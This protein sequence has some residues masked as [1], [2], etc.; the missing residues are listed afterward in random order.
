MSFRFIHNA[1]LHFDAPLTT[2]ALR[3]PAQA[4]S[5]ASLTAF[6]RI[7]DLCIEEAVAFLLITDDLS[8]GS[9]SAATTPR[10]LKQELLRL[11][12]A[13]TR[14]F[15]IRG[16]HDALAHL[17]AE[18]A[19]LLLE[20]RERANALLASRF[21][22]LAFDVGL[23]RY[24]DRHRSAMLARASDAFSQLSRGAYSGLAAQP[25][26]AQEVLVVLP[27]HGG[28]EL[29]ADLSKGTRFQLYLALRI[30]GYHEPAQSRPTLPVIADDI[31]ETFDND[32]LPAAFVLL[33]EMSRVGQ[34]I[35]L[36]RHRHLCK[37][38]LTACPGANIIE[39]S[40][41][42]KNKPCRMMPRLSRP[43]LPLRRRPRWSSTRRLPP[44][45]TL[46]RRR[47]GWQS[48]KAWRSRMSEQSLPRTYD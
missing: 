8:D 17:A 24:R 1:D 38:A 12:A 10:F 47:T 42:R 27:A 16:N 4:V 40:P 23:R 14:C 15:I 30:A 37:I 39:L 35:Y 43:R 22:L 6:A 20:A 25:D 3:D 28:A 48:S 31:M 5:A 21:G 41:P 26:G 13:G 18:R 29:A 45:S 32:R 46:P 34:V 33:E 2:T 36:T 44:R 7:V 9:H 19:N 11:N